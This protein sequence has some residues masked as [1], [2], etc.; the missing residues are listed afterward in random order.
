MRK[1]VDRFVVVLGWCSWIGKV[2]LRIF[3]PHDAWRGQVLFSLAFAPLGVFTRF[4]LATHLNDRLPSF[5]LGT[6]AANVLGTAILAMVWDLPH[7]QIGSVV[8]C[9]LFKGVENGYCA[10]VTTVSTLVLEL[11]SLER[12]YAYIY[13]AASFFVSFGLMVI[14]AGS[15]QWTTR[16]LETCTA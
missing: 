15:L 13:C 5:P 4:Y 6:L 12:R 11:S 14:V 9:Q 8:G 2:L 7:I 1:I 3:P 10:V 16:G